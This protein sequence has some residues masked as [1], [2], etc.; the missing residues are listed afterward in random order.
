MAERTADDQVADPHDQEDGQHAEHDPGHRLQQVHFDLAPVGRG[1]DAGFEEHDAVADGDRRQQVEQRNDRRLP[2][3]IDLRPH[4][5]QQRAERGLVHHR[6]QR[7]EGNEK[8]QHLLQ[9]LLRYGQPQFFEKNRRELDPHHDDVGRDADRH[10]EHHRI[11]VGVARPQDVPEIP[12]ATEVE[13]H[14]DPG[15]RVAEQAGQQRRADQRVVM[16]AVEDVDQQ[17]HREAA[18]GE[19]RTDDY[20]DDHPDAPR[21]AVVEVGHRAEAEDE[22]DEQYRHHGRDQQAA[23]H[24]RRI[25]QLAANRG[26]GMMGAHDCPPFGVSSSGTTLRRATQV[27]PA[28]TAM[29]MISPPYSEC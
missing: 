27:R 11:G 21:V 3:R 13:Q 1:G 18:A 16:A 8:E 4:D 23:D 29:G 10:L 24:C 14:P 9:F 6:Q 17:G 28:S 15:Q 7:A 12:P 22:T 26:G 25:E 20:I 5:H 2:Q 19:G